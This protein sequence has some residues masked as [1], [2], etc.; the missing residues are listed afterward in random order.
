[1]E[2]EL[3]LDCPCRSESENRWKDGEEDCCVAAFVF[4]GEGVSGVAVWNGCSEEWKK[5]F[6][7][8]LNHVFKMEE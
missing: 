6:F 1:M 7:E 2:H 4:D 8:F 3:R 5:C